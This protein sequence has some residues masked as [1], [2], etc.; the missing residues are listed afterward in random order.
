MDILYLFIA[1]W[2]LAC[3]MAAASL[4]KQQRASYQHFPCIDSVGATYSK[5]PVDVLKKKG[6]LNDCFLFYS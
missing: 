4:I 5:F 6:E 3:S 2:I 1:K